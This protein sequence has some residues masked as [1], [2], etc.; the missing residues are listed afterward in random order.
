MRFIDKK[1]KLDYLLSLIS[2]QNTGTASQLAERLC[3]S[4]PTAEKYLALLRED[5]HNIGYCTRRRTYYQI[6]EN[7]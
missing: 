4:K 1:Q 3:I 2:E 7:K 5:G 6:S